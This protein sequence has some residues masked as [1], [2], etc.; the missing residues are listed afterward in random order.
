MAKERNGRWIWEAIKLLAMLLLAGAA[1]VAGYGRISERI[2][3]N[4]AEDNK[5][6]QQ[7]PALDMRVTRVEE[8]LKSLDKGF[9]EFQRLTLENQ[10][11]ILQ[12]LRKP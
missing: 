12:E 9:T 6:H 5:V 8:N 4:C 2:E 3:N 7:V 1:A 11:Q 10:K